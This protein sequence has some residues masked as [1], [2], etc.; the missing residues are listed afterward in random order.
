MTEQSKNNKIESRQTGKQKLCPLGALTAGRK[1]G[2]C[3]RQCGDELP[4]LYESLGEFCPVGG[5]NLWFS[6]VKTKLTTRQNRAVHQRETGGVA[7]KS[8]PGR[9][10]PDSFFW[11]SRPLRA[12]RRGFWQ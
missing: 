7:G 10:V 4:T 6:L 3:S 1:T 9:G 11:T 2:V 5:K 8:G 12:R